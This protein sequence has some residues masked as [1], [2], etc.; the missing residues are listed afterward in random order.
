MFFNKLTN[1]A[2]HL[3]TITV[4]IF[5][6][7]SHF[8]FPTTVPDSEVAKLA[9]LFSEPK[10]ETV[11]I[12]HFGVSQAEVDTWK[13]ACGEDKDGF[14]RKI[15]YYFRNTGHT[16]KVISFFNKKEN[17]LEFLLQLRFCC[18]LATSIL[19]IRTFLRF[20]RF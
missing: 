10:L 3:Q 1:K 17:I 6:N 8:Q 7:W 18:V 15:L 2:K 5:K 9:P 11:A 20:V 12:Q 14:K 13:A 16:R 19:L 4:H